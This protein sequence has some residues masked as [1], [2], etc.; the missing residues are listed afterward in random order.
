MLRRQLFKSLAAL[1]VIALLGLAGIF[2]FK[3][4]RNEKALELKCPEATVTALPGYSAK[5]I[6]QILISKG[7]IKAGENIADFDISRFKDEYWFLKDAQGVEG[8]LYPDTYRFCLDTPPEDVIKRFLDN[9]ETR[10]KTVFTSLTGSYDALI[11]AS[12]VEKEVPDNEEERRLVAGL[13]IG[14]MR[15]N[16]RLQVDATLCYAKYKSICPENF[17]VSPKDK[18]TDSPYNTYKNKGLPPGPI[19]NPDISAIRAAIAPKTSEYRYYIS[20]PITKR[21]IFAKTLDEH[22]RN[23]VKYLR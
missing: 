4:Y 6:D 3:Q 9:F 13:L 16:M 14:R 21:T 19:G 20:D 23:V 2:A 15:D 11:L 18:E 12:L 10:T 22:N 7:V 17:S 1:T 8:F 5:Q